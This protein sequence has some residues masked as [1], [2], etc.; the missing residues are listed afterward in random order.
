MLLKKIEIFFKCN[1]ALKR[2]LEFR[3]YNIKLNNSI[4]EYHEQSLRLQSSSNCRILWRNRVL[5]GNETN[6]Q[7][8]HGACK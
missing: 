5:Y 1:N 2:N 7:I 6:L 8:P 4:F 3:F